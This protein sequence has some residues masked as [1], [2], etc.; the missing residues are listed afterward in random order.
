MAKAINKDEGP[1]CL[2]IESTPQSDRD[3]NIVLAELFVR[4]VPVRWEQLYQNRL[5]KVFVPAS[6]KKF[7]E[8][9]CE[10]PLKLGNQVLKGEILH[11]AS[12]NE[13]MV[14]PFEE[15]IPGGMQPVEGK[16]NIADLLIDLTHN[17]TGFEKESISLGSRLLDDLNLDSIK[18]ADLI[19]QAART[20]GIGGQIDPSKLSNNTLG[21]IRNRLF[22]LSQARL[23]ASAQGNGESVLKRY[24]NKPWV[25]NFVSVLKNEEIAT[26]N[27]NQLKGL[28]NIVI[29]SEKSEDGIADTLGKEFSK[30]RVQK[31]HFGE[32]P[33]IAKDDSIDCV[34]NILPKGQKKTN[35]SAEV[36]N[37]IIVRAHQLVGVAAS[38]KIKKDCF[39]VL[40]GF[41]GGDFG[42]N[43]N[44]KSIASV[45]M[46]ALVST[47]YLEYPSLKVRVLDFDQLA[48]EENISSKIIDELQT[49]ESFSAVGYD[50][51]L[52]RRVIYY[53]NSQPA[54]YKKRGIVWSKNDVV[55]VTGGAKGITAEC[56]LEFARSTKAQMVL[57]GRSPVPKKSDEDSEILKTLEKFDK[58]GFKASYYQC[59]VTNPKDV[60]VV[61]EKIKSK[62]GKITGFIHGAGL[63]SLKR[64]KQSSVDEAFTESLPKVMGA[65]NVCSALNGD[66]KLIAAI[67]SIIGITGM[68]GSGWY[69]LANEVLNLYLHQ[70]KG[71]NPQTE[72]VTI[73][74]SIWDEVG[75]G[76]K[77]GSVSKLAEKG[78]AAI[79][80]KE[81]VG[82]F[83]QLIENSPESQ[84]VMV[85]ARVAGIDTLKTMVLKPGQFRFIEKIEYFMP[86][87]ELIVKAHLNIKDDPYLLDHNWK[88]SL[89]FPFVFGLEAMVQ[90]VASLLE[91]E[92]F[93][94]IK[95]KNV[96]LERP[97][98][99]PEDSGTNIEIHA[100]VFERKGSVQ[101]I[102]VE[103]YSQESAY[104]EPH[105]SAIFE[106]NSKELKVQKL[107][108][109][110]MPLEHIDLDVNTELYGPILFQGRMF[111][112]IRKTH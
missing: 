29:L 41:G 52:T 93:D 80:V 86:N 73:A 38:D 39:I 97:I 62:V 63:N 46:K 12:Q 1:V 21:E 23:G 77:L 59:D 3:L 104:I 51:Q 27:V 17:I 89:L 24:Q 4:S 7:I 110:K 66:L 20:L 10:R 100:E 84:Q 69:G 99:V 76:T 25:R 33:K 91:I 75:M 92:E 105:F 82:R 87:V 50:T 108:E 78:I 18:A 107:A 98:N 35:L 26:R 90:A 71:Q 81:G 6:R 31:I 96:N 47:L 34:I 95:V 40:V 2:S 5:V 60:A 88:G 45:G 42:E 14:Q 79:P 56:A 67:T 94:R 109:S 55:L 30:G 43:N 72:V 22:E 58:E 16:D 74:Y 49:Y 85:A 37:E 13:E 32:K 28:K 57:L 83:R 15:I 44:L 19:G 70:Y 36:L 64:L 65:V 101:D 111:H 54:N 106:I 102:K 103:I 53:E 48:S 9:Q 68:E 8:N 11:T 61:V 112:C